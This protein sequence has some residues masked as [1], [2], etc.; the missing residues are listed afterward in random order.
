MRCHIPGWELTGLGAL[1]MLSV[2][3]SRYDNGKPL[4]TPPQNVANVLTLG[5]FKAG[6][7]VLSTAVS[8]APT[9]PMVQP[10]PP[11]DLSDVNDP[12]Y[13]RATALRTEAESLH[14]LLTV[15][16]DGRPDWNSI[17]SH[18][19]GGCMDIKVRCDQVIKSLQVHNRNA[20][21]AT[22]TAIELAR[23]GK[24]VR[25]RLPLSPASD[26]RYSCTLSL[27]SLLTS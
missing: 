5:L 8:S 16:P 26:S 15:G 20:G 21:R 25:R 10:S 14:V 4:L 23:R 22:R 1:D 13:Q 11:V 7:H 27:C 9:T 19:S 12:G 18:Q 6:K 24:E 17:K 3:S 2:W